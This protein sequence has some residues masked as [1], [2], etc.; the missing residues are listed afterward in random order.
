MNFATRVF[1]VLLRLAIGWHFLVEGLHKFDADK[2]FSSETYLRESNGPLA[3][4][5]RSIAGDDVVEKL[6]LGSLPQDAAGDASTEAARFPQAL[7]HDW[8]H[9]RDRFV[10]HNG[11]DRPENERVRGEVDNTFR[12]RKAEFVHWVL[13][14]KSEVTKSS[15]YSSEKASFRK[16]IAERLD[17]YEQKKK[18]ISTFEKRLLEP[19]FEAGK[20]THERTEKDLVAAKQELTSMR[21]D[22]RRDIRQQTI[23][24]ELA[25]QETLEREQDTDHKRSAMTEPHRLP[26][27]HW[28]SRQRYLWFGYWALTVLAVWSFLACFFWI[29]W[30]T[31][32]WTPARWLFWTILF[33]AIL[34]G[35]LG[36][37]HEL[38]LEWWKDWN[39]SAFDLR[40]LMIWLH[41]AAAVGLVLSLG[42]TL[43]GF[44]RNGGKRDKT[45]SLVSWLTCVTVLASGL[46]VFLALLLFFGQSWVG[47]DRLEWADG[48]VCWGVL[49]IGACLLLGF[50]TRFSALL[51]ALILLSFY[52][53]MP[54][55]PWLPANPLS[56]GHYLW[57]NKN[58]IES[59][60]LLVL[61]TTAA[62]KWAGLD[63]MLCY[64]N[65]RVW[66]ETKT[67]DPARRSPSA[68]SPPNRADRVI[69]LPSSA[70]YEVV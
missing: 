53:A 5:F 47:F 34:A 13:A 63:G 60:A 2:P 32:A 23:T 49:T 40:G 52:L 56:E 67:R 44:F 22:L 25:L 11:L 51:G 64:L 12:Q 4:Q 66:K 39:R 58:V 8:D 50:C 16:T 29:G 10:E 15:P 65:P 69:P 54:P 27:Q 59:V 45:P 21:N 37:A 30:N 62:G 18:E 48:L 43:I 24:M 28:T 20:F 41:V 61:A 57:I 36:I 26:W 7:A 55:L 1:L 70:D 35:S 33:G 31:R 42:L 38:H 19:S 46:W 3:P 17:D 14:S 68:P 6:T 9:Y